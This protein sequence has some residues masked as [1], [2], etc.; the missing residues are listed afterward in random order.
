MTTQ[1]K[2]IQNKVDEVKKSK[3]EKEYT[4][5]DLIVYW[6]LSHC[7]H[8]GKCTAMLPQ[9]FDMNKRGNLLKLV[10]LFL[11]TKLR[12][13]MRTEVFWRKH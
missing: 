1:N 10:L 2:E 7:S 6:N 5:E 9:V 11:Q 3:K 13:K 12:E 4:T 8:A